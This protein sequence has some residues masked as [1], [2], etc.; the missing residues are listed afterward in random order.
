LI[1]G[2]LESRKP[3]SDMKCGVCVLEKVDKLELNKARAHHEQRAERR[4]HPVD[5][6]L[7]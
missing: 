5:L 2:S 4:H 6:W 3:G 1:Q 7:G